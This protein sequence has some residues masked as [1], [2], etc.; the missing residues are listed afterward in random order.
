MTGIVFAGFP[1]SYAFF[2]G[3]FDHVLQFI[4][5]LFFAPL[6]NNIPDCGNEPVVFCFRP[7]CNS[8][9]IFSKAVERGA[10][11]EPGFPELQDA[12]SIRLSQA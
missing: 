11:P 8:Y 10:M 4:L 9:V 5:C 1:A 7:D 12:H 2:R 3:I 6:G